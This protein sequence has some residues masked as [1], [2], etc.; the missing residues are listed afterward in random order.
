MPGLYACYYKQ[1]SSPGPFPGPKK[2]GWSVPGSSGQNST[3]LNDI[4][5]SR[6]AKY[7]TM[8]YIQALLKGI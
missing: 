1:A 4:W 5:S 3:G 7:M 6:P 8:E 2:P